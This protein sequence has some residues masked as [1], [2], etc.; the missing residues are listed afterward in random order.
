MS[1]MDLMRALE[2]LEEAVETSLV[3]RKF[4]SS[5]FCW[6]ELCKIEEGE[7]KN[8]KEKT[9][10]LLLRTSPL[11]FKATRRLAEGELV[12]QQCTFHGH[13]H[14]SIHR[15]SQSCNNADSSNSNVSCE[16]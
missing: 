13:I 8:T 16:H 9:W 15:R 1:T 4:S 7:N 10:R 12:N 5:I 6:K 3:T 2:M 14:G 11:P